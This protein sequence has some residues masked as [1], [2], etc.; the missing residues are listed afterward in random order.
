MCVS[1]LTIALTNDTYHAMFTGISS[2]ERCER[3]LVLWWCTNKIGFIQSTYLVKN[4]HVIVE[5][6][7][8]DYISK[9]TIVYVKYLGTFRCTR[10]HIGQCQA[11]Q[12]RFILDGSLPCTT[13]TLQICVW[14][15]DT[16]NII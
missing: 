13:I 15:I 5:D 4:N 6:I 16:S 7:K 3:K 1:L 2:T 10:V 12:G 9:T 8:G 11:L 14:P